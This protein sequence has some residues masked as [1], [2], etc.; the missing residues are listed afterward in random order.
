[1]IF[2]KEKGEAEDKMVRQHH[3]LNGHESEPTLGDSERQG[4]LACSTESMGL[5]RLGHSDST[6]TIKILWEF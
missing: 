3:P 2:N 6:T 4:S 1:M 5:Q